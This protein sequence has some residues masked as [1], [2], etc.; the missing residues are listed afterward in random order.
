MSVP[1]FRSLQDVVAASGEGFGG[2][3]ESPPAGW[4]SVALKHP[5]ELT[6]YYTG[7]VVEDNPDFIV[8]SIY[9]SESTFPKSRTTVTYGGTQ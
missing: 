6:E 7:P 1:G 5:W 4:A 8:I 2:A 9:G 3:M